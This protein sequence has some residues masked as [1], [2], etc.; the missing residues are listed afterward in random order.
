MF[1]IVSF[2]KRTIPLLFHM[3]TSKPSTKHQQGK[4]QKTD[5]ATSMGLQTLGLLFLFLSDLNL[6]RGSSFVGSTVKVG[7]SDI[8][9]TICASLPKSMQW[10]VFSL[11]VFP[12]TTSSLELLIHFKYLCWPESTTY[13]RRV[14]CVVILTLFKT[15]RDARFTLFLT[16]CV[17][18]H[19][20]SSYT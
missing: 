12:F 16:S 3:E 1:P 2:K 20:S 9:N 4:G 14:Y 18:D 6:F 5:V 8:N 11:F 15:L 19:S 13:R 7:D 10:G 17:S